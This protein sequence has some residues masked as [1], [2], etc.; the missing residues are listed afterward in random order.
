MESQYVVTYCKASSWGI[1]DLVDSLSGTAGSCADTTAN[2]LGSALDR[3]TDI[4]L[5]GMDSRGRYDRHF[6]YFD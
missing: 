1:S 3:T 2:C 5:T 4:K 6:C